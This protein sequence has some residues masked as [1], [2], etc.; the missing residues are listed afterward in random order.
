MIFLLRIAICDDN[1]AITSEIEQLILLSCKKQHIQCTID[2][3]F[4]GISLYQKMNTYTYYDLIYLD[5]EME[6][7]TGIDVAKFLRTSNLPTL[8]IFVSAYDT[9][10]NQ[11]LELETFKF[12]SKP[13]DPIKFEVTFSKA[14][15]RILLKNDFFTFS[16]RHEIFKVPINEIIYIESNRRTIILHTIQTTFNFISKLDTVEKTLSTSTY[17]FIRIH[18]SYLVNFYYV[19]S[20]SPSNLFLHDG[21]AFP[22]S[23][24]Y[25]SSVEEKYLQIGEFL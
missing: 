22:I 3:F 16:F 4:D 20:L 25:R 7:M 12:L 11:L 19:Q 23:P 15:R 21:T 2:I 13:I 10:C 24:K 14:L 6:K 8:L 18:Q 1:P 17:V 9:Y 5:I